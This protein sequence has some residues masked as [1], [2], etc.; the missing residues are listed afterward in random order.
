MLIAKDRPWE[1][2][3]LLNPAFNVVLLHGFIEGYHHESGNWPEYPVIFFA[4]PFVLPERSRQHIRGHNVLW[5]IQRLLQDHPELKVDFA[6]RIHSTAFLTRE[7][8]I[9][10]FHLQTFDVDEQGR[11]MFFHQR[12]VSRLDWPSDDER[13][14]CLDAAKLLGR[15]FGR[16]DSTES[17]FTLMGVRP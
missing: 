11:I 7:A 15:W 8:L 3:T 10:G 9:L 12:L 2:R 14:D 1:I 17:L 16:V 4:L 5:G 13:R 6:K